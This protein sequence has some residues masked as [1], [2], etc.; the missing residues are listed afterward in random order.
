MSLTRGGSGGLPGAAEKESYTATV[1]GATK[2]LWQLGHS[3]SCQQLCDAPQWGQ[4]S[5]ITSF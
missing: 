1:E 5:F 3:I 2:Y 4:S